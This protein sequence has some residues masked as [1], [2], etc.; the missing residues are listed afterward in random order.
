VSATF[1]KHK[2]ILVTRPLGRADKLC[3]LINDSGGEAIH[4]PV[5]EII[6]ANKTPQLLK[7]INNL[8]LY[9]VA[10][11]IS[12]S[13]VIETLN[14]FSLPNEMNV[15]AI[16]R[17]TELILKEHGIKTSIKST[18]FNSEVL[19]KHPVFQSENIKHKKIVIFR[20]VG[21]RELLANELKARGA[22]TDYAETYQ[23]T[24]AR[25]PPLTTK[26]IKQLAAIT[27]SSNEGLDNL[28]LLVN[29]QQTIVEIPIIVA[30]PK[31]FGSAK[32]YGFRSI[33]LADNA[34]DEACFSTITELFH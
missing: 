4:Y 13:A 26:Q 3:Q 1:L 14:Q 28:M 30:S 29:K 33:H 32:S 21:G 12:P 5:I 31:T 22:I 24:L 9:D 20:G 11:F 7:I 6:P 27:I 17:K 10:I 25:L 15:V 2:K 8:P 23:R 18:G 34:S 19:L 16:G